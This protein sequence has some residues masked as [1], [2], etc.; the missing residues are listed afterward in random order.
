M[1]FLFLSVF[2]FSFSVFFGQNQ[3]YK[4]VLGIKGGFPGYGSV[5]L[6]HNLKGAK[7]IE[8]SM[9]GLGRR[10]DG[11]GFYIL[12]DFEI[13]NPLKD[14]FL[15]YYGAGALVGFSSNSLNSYLH[16]APNAV[17]G[18]EYVFDDLP[19]NISIETGPYLFI[20][21]RVA[22]DWGGGIALRYVIK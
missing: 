20:S 18:L 5:N 4:T 19:L 6:K 12:G 16:C 21:P 17:V 10:N 11:N 7:F 3:S 9:G 13:N 2:V 22:F 15:W 1:K 8:L 14:G